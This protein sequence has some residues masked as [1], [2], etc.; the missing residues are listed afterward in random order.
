MHPYT[1][2]LLSAVPAPGPAA[3]RAAQA[4]PAD[5]RRPQPAEPAARVPVPHPVL[6]GAGGAAGPTSRRWRSWRPG[7]GW[8]ATSRRTRRRDVVARPLHG[9]RLEPRRPGT[10]RHGRATRRGRPGPGADTCP[11]RMHY[12]P[13]GGVRADLSLRARRPA[14]PVRRRSAARA[15]SV[16]SR[17]R[18][19]P[20]ARRPARPRRS[21]PVVLTD[22]TVEPYEP[23]LGA[24]RR[25]PARAR[26]RTRCSSASTR[27]GRT[28]RRRCSPPRCSPAGGRPWTTL[29]C[30]DRNRVVLEQEL[31]GLAALGVEGVLCVTG[32]VRAPGVR[33]RR[34]A[35]LRPRRHP[36]RR[37]GR[38][39]GAGRAPSRRRPRRRRSAL[40]PARVAQKQ[41]AGARLCVLNH[42]GSPAAVARFVADARAR[43]GHA[44]VRRGRRRLHRRALGAGPAGASRA[45]TSTARRSTRVLRAPGPGRGGHRGGG[46][47]GAG[48]ARDPRGGRGEPVGPRR[49]AR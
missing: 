23:G 46:G 34:H 32:D 26:R 13:C 16:P 36:A 22:L 33:A 37:A 19:P 17:R 3:P 31:M 42:V 4:D 11:K 28:C 30:R 39:D 24:P 9:G 14:L 10:P 35:G 47:R 5:R 8:R 43:R 20:P 40:R 15:G 38:R 21:P 25:R 45:C 27:T 6:E 29:S 18:R 44:A 2:A 12:G 49:R 48:A 1:V 41:R 7:T